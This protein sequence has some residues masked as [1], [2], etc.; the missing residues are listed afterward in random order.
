MRAGRPG[1]YAG[2]CVEVRMSPRRQPADT[3][4]AVITD[5]DVQRAVEA[6]LFCH[7]SVDD[8]GIVVSVKDGVVRLSGYARNLLQKY[9]AEDAVRRVAG[10]AAVANDIQLQPGAGRK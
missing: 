6:E 5:S 10:V 9:R 7:P 1:R 8:A 3:A 2:K 4:A